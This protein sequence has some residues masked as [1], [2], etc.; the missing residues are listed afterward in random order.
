MV[1]VAWSVCLAGLHPSWS[2][3][4]QNG[5]T[6]LGAIWVV[7]SDGPKE[8]RIR[9]GSRSLVCKGQFL[10]GKG[11]AHCKVYWPWAVRRAETAELI[12]MPFR[13]CT[14]VGPRKH[15]LDRGAQWHHLANTTELSVHTDWLKVLCPTRHKISH[16]RNVLPIS[17]HST[18]ETKSN[19]TKAHI[20]K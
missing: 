4:L 12:K 8:P 10:V 17:W 9:L 7:D 5:W 14:R 1:D 13:I 6:D 19:T 3:A 18:E 2:S 11:T 16:F 20:H 15:V